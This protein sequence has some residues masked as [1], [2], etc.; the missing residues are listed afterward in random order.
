MWVL[1]GDIAGWQAKD[2]GYGIYAVTQS[3]IQL[4][5][6]AMAPAWGKK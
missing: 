1:R 6:T 5:P 2:F 3:Q 4:D